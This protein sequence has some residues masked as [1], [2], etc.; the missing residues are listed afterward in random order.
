MIDR[1][2]GRLREIGLGRLD[3][4]EVVADRRRGEVLRELDVGRP[5][6]LEL[7]DP[8]RLADDLGDRARLLDALVPLRHGLEHPHD[9]DV[10]VRFLVEL[11]ETGL[12]GDRDHRRVV[13]ERVGDPGDEVGRARTEGR[14]RDRRPAGQPPVDVGHE[15][16][17]LLV[18]GRDVTDAAS[19][20]LRASRMSI[21]SSP[22]TEKT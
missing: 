6:L 14:H 22:G 8:E 3:R 1:F 11:V 13:E 17:A 15:G 16:R 21:V 12:A 7:G 2:V 4:P 10:L 9:V 5:R 20:R 18:A 19:A